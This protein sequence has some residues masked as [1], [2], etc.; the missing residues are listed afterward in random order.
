MNLYDMMTDEM[1]DDCIDHGVFT[2]EELEKTMSKGGSM[3]W[4][5]IDRFIETL[6]DLK[7]TLKEMKVEILKERD[8]N[9]DPE[10]KPCPFCG[11]KAELYDGDYKIKHLS[12]CFLRP[13]YNIDSTWCVSKTSKEAWNR[14]A[15]ENDHFDSLPAG[16]G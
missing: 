11:V 8:A 7:E 3:K 6:D 1:K 10:G 15:Y 12:D 14:R 4:I 16:R 2:R 5:L 13:T 9:I